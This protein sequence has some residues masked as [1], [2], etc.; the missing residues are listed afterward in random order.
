VAEI[1]V[2]RLSALGDVIHTIPAVTF[3]RTA[4]PDARVKWVVEEPYRELVEL[5]SGAEVIPVRLKK[6]SRAL[7]HSRAEM[8]AAVRAMRGA[9]VAIDFQGLIKSAALAS[10]SRAPLRFGFGAEAI[11]EKAA[12]LFL[13]RRVRVDTGAHVIE[14]NLELARWSAAA[15]VGV[16]AGDKSTAEGGGAPPSTWSAFPLGNFPDLASS[17]VLLPGAGKANKLWPVE[18][19]RELAHRLGPRAVA[20]WGP[21]ER[22][23]ADQIG[24]RVAPPTT[25]RQLAW[26]LQH[27]DLVIGADTGPLHLAAALGTKVIGLY[28][29]TNPR[30]NGPFGQLH[31]CLDRY[32]T[33][34]MMETI[35]VDEVMNKVTEVLAQ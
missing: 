29:P 34:K 21:G 20:V 2:F 35:T 6:W 26:V 13:N 11:R 28:G 33:T 1:V 8:R 14:Q 16:V 31:R 4:L 12:L 7:L 17:I 15:L 25:L 10:V 9:D 32:E 22:E 5:V 30:R 27:A 18:R 3:L 24:A 23:L 19:F